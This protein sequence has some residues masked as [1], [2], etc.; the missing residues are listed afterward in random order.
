MTPVGRSWPIKGFLALSTAVLCCMPSLTA[1]QGTW[2]DIGSPE[3]T[4]VVSEDDPA[5]TWGFPPYPFG[6]WWPPGTLVFAFLGIS[7]ESD[8]LVE[9]GSFFSDGGCGCGGDLFSPT[10][11]RLHYDDSSL[12][13]PESELKLFKLVWPDWVLEP[14]AIQDMDANT[15]TVQR[16]ENIVGVV[17]YGIGVSIPTP[18]LGTSWGKIKSLYPR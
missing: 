13:V 3:S 14:E 16:L 18:V 9:Y 17:R 15:F 7:P 12:D 5:S 2:F 4:I 6:D 1:A 8:F 10:T 11:Y